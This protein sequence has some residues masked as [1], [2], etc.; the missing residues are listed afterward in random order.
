[1]PLVTQ[2]FITAA[3]EH[4]SDLPTL[5][6]V[7][8]SAFHD[9]ILSECRKSLCMGRYMRLKHDRLEDTLHTGHIGP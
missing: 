4:C 2:Q 8:A 3:G 9:A 1:M 6:T 5:G 7:D